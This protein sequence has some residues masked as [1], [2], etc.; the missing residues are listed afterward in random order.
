MR[1]YVYIDGFNLYYGSVRHTKNKWLDLMA[2]SKDL[3]GV[4]HDILK[5]KYFTARVK[6]TV[7]D[8][9]KNTRQ[10]TYLRALK[11]HIPELE[12]RFGHFSEREKKMR[13]AVPNPPEYSAKVIVPEE[14]G[15][16]VNLAV[17]F[18][19]DAWL[20]HYDCGVI[21]SNDSDLAEPVRIVKKQR[22]KKVVII[23]PHP[24]SSESKRLN[25]YAY[26]T[27]TL[28]KTQLG[29]YQL[30]TMIRGTTI[31]KPNQW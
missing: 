11:A 20:D 5:I 8:P 26:K 25:Q 31:H 29:Q 2:M 1:T 28:D 18:L 6:P 9:Q 15:S 7:K 4:S 27:I 3:L 10:D 22:G 23:N 17:H 12:I 19:N 13:L 16:D 14:K 30:P 21:I 24:K